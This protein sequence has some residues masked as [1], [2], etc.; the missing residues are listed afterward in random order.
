MEDDVQG[1]GDFDVTG[2]ILARE[3]KFRMGEEV[4]YVGV[5]ARY[6]I[7]EAENFPAFF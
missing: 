1:A 7:V 2:D 3:T 6:E 5:A 4:G